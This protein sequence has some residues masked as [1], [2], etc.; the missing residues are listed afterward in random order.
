MSTPNKHKRGD[1]RYDADGEIERFVNYNK[2]CKNG[3]YWVKEE[4]YRTICD[5]YEENRQRAREKYADTIVMQKM[6]LAIASHGVEV[7]AA[8]T[9]GEL[10]AMYKHH[11]LPE[12]EA[13]QMEQAKLVEETR[14]LNH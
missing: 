7:P 14:I 12:L 4:K 10:W 3:E 9:Q 6:R 5:K 2:S 11:Y 1:I 8:A 13:H